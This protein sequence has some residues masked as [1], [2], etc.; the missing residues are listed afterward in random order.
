M[1][2]YFTKENI[3]I[4]NEEDRAFDSVVQKTYSFEL[5]DNES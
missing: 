4:A 3:L 2:T 1:N 5:G